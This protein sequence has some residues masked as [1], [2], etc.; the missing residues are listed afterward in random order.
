MAKILPIQNGFTAGELSP[1]MYTRSNSKGYMEGLHTLQNMF[2]YTHGPASKRPGFGYLHHVDGEKNGRVFPFILSNSAS[3]I[4]AAYDLTIEALDPSGVGVGDI[5]SVNSFFNSGLTGWTPIEAGSANIIAISNI[6]YI[7]VGDQSSA[8]IE[9]TM[10]GMTTGVPHLV[11]LKRV[12]DLDRSVRIEVGQ[13][14]SFNDLLDIETTSDHVSFEFTPTNATVNIRATA[15]SGDGDDAALTIFGVAEI[16]AAPIFVTP[17]AEDDLN[18]IQFKMPPSDDAMYMVHPTYPPQKLSYNKTT[19]VWA[20]V[21]VVFVGAPAEWVAGNYPSTVTFFQGRSWWGGTPDQPE[22]FW[23]S[24]SGVPEDLTTGPLADD[25]LVFTIAERGAIRWMVG[26]KSL[27]IGTDSGEHIASGNASVDNAVGIIEPGNV[28]VVQQSAY[29]SALIQPQK[30]GN[31]AFFVT[32]DQ[33]KLRDTSYNWQEDA[34][35]SVD[36]TF[37][38]EHITQGLITRIAYSQHPNNLIWGTTADGE[39]VCCTYEPSQKVVGWHRHPSWGRVLDVTN[40]PVR[41]KSIPVIVRAYTDGDNVNKIAIEYLNDAHYLDTMIIRNYESPVTTVDGLDIFE[42]LTVDVLVDGAVHPKVVVTSGQITTNQAG[43]NFEVGKAYSGKMITLPLAMQQ[44]GTS[45]TSLMKRYNMIY[46]RMINSTLPLIN[47][48]RPS[49]RDPATPMDEPQPAIV[50]EDARVANTGWDR[51]AQITIEQDLPL[52]LTVV[53]VFG[54][55][56]GEG[57]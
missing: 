37:A 11:V 6:C 20:F 24:K 57:L 40:V 23:G 7:D 1:R 10:A 4:I 5:K 50:F 51:F 34:W 13:G 31:S 46:A 16:A 56:A 32:P 18:L 41:G 43:V 17:W 44:E 30:I 53:G 54:E 29:G 36:M 8:G 28:N 26:T 35:V 48:T 49:T 3:F 39:L 27:L 33:R 25:G 14:A 12:D 55:V 15:L 42:G 9:Q 47:G 45:G 52:P 2:A 22:T 19:G 21:P 38:S